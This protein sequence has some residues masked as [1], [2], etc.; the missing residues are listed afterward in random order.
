ME[1]HLSPP[2][3]LPPTL[4]LEHAAILAWLL[5]GHTTSPSTGHPLATRELHPVAGKGQMVGYAPL[6]AEEELARLEAA[7]A[8]AEGGGRWRR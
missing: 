3:P 1:H 2:P 7:L 5:R 8:V 6:L 4:P